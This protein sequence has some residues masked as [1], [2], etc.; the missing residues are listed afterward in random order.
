M[1]ASKRGYRDIQNFSDD[2]EMRESYYG[3]LARGKH[4]YISRYTNT[5]DGRQTQHRLT[6]EEATQIKKDWDTYGWSERFIERWIIG[7]IA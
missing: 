4:F 7:T 3:L 2:T 1:M 6:T 5:N